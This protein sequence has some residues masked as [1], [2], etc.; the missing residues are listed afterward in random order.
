MSESLATEILRSI[1]RNPIVE[2]GNDLRTSQIP[3]WG[4]QAREQLQGSPANYDALFGALAGMYQDQLNAGITPGIPK[5]AQPTIK[6]GVLEDEN[7]NIF[8][9]LKWLKAST[10]PE[11][12]RDA[13]EEI[14]YDWEFGP[15]STFNQ[16]QKRSLPLY[17]RLGAYEGFLVPS[18]QTLGT[19]KRNMAI[20]SFAS[21]LFQKE[22]GE[23]F[24]EG[25]SDERSL[26]VEN[27]IR[28]AWGLPP[29]AR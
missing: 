22:F 1:F 28:E 25:M 16:D 24:S 5:T 13:A 11:W 15:E 19:P 3:E 7:M 20:D 18:D 12:G 17:G 29:L 26:E 23:P 10:I 2:R 9:R 14:K 21:N 6:S 27:L 4:E 8:E